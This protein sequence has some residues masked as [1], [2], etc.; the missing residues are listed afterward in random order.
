MTDQ[1]QKPYTFDQ[2]IRFVLSAAVAVAVFALLRHLSDVLLP[3]VAAVIIA[4]LLNPLV[5]VFEEKTHRRGL[6]VAITLGGLAIFC[7]ALLA[8]IVPLAAS[9]VNRFRD[10]VKNLR[11]DL[12]PAVQAV[13]A[14][15][16]GGESKKPSDS[17]DPDAQTAEAKRPTLGLQELRIGWNKYRDG[18]SEGLSRRERF[19]LLLTE[20]EGTTSGD[21]IQRAVEYTD[22]DE[23]TQLIIELGKRVAAGGW[24]VLSFGLN[25][26]LA[27]TGL[28][29]VL[30]YL[31]FLLLDYPQYARSWRALLPPRYGDSIFEFL[32]EFSVAMKRY[33]RGQAVVAM[34]MAALFS[35]G[36]SVVG[37][38]MAVPLGLFVGLLNMIPY[39]Q[40]IG[41]LP[42]I[43]LAGLGAVEQESSFALSIGLAFGVFAVAQL[44]QDAIIMPR[45]MGQA[46]GLSPIAVLLGIFIWGK[47]LGFMGLLLAIPLT[48]LFIAYYRRYVLLHAKSATTI[49]DD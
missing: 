1:K 20:I 35:I 10:N 14:V 25:L 49:R 9:Q 33:F 19:G 37:L 39:L 26:V 2:V 21:L 34:M 7:F 23:F 43:M 48:C 8:I 15:G 6:A 47:L 28:I 45:I 42:A 29:I 3:F 11:E 4:Y 17:E 36:F 41:I 31:V 38:P 40:I 12:A 30:L 44:I 46:T 16:Q 22:T 32:Q 24:S 18:A 13:Q 27:M 5:N